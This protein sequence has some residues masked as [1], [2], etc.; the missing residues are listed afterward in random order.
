MNRSIL[1]PALLAAALAGALAG[2]AA[3]QNPYYPNPYY[4]PYWGP[5]SGPGNTLAG[6][7]Q[8]IDATGDLYVQQEKAR[9]E[10]QKYYQEKIATKKMAFDEA[11]YEK[12]NTPKFTEEQEKVLVQQVRRVM[13]QPAPVEITRGDTLN[14][15]L[16]WLRMCS[17]MGPPGPPIQLSPAVL[18]QIN[19]SPGSGGTEAT[20]G[21]APAGAGVLKN[22]GKVAWPLMLRGPTQK[23]V[24]QLLPAAVKAAADG[25]LEPTQYT[26]LTTN[27]LN[28][29]EEW[30]KKYH[31]E[32]I[33]GGTFLKG[34]HFLDDLQASLKILQDPNAAK[35]LDGSYA[36]RGHNV[37]ELVENMAAQGLQFAPATP[38]TESAYYSLHNAFV[39][40]ARA[41]QPSGGFQTMLGPPVPR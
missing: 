14:L 28:L 19:V 13:N 5:G 21:K 17:E 1:T 37:Q 35:F 11:A 20:Q 12:A 40:Y 27:V 26:Q 34:K 18:K 9:I 8:V 41:A 30:R 6:G 16:P 36:A 10:R 24:D 39:A 33:D 29:Q 3:A 38:G 31:K 23:K 7:A 4:P 2:P 32:Q 15:M 25:T 22:G